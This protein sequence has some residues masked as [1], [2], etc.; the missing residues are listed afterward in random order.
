MLKVSYRRPHHERVLKRVPW[1]AVMDRV[2]EA[3]RCPE[4][5][6]HLITLGITIRHREDFYICSILGQ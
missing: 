1:Q 4:V 5:T 3:S 6:L 2:E